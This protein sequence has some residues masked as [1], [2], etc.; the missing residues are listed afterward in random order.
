MARPVPVRAGDEPLAAAV[1]A[2][3]RA[4][5][6]ERGRQP[7]AK[8]EEVPPPRRLGLKVVDEHPGQKGV[9]VQPQPGGGGEVEPRV[10]QPRALSRLGRHCCSSHHGRRRGHLSVRRLLSGLHVACSSRHGRG[11]GDTVR[12]QLALARAG[13]S[14][15]LSELEC[16]AVRIRLA[17][18]LAL[19]QRKAPPLAVCSGPAAGSSA[20]TGRMQC[21]ERAKIGHTVSKR[22]TQWRGGGSRARHA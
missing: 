19:W 21:D 15:V 8:A 11:E 5:A 1:V 3:R 9:V 7:V 2:P 14:K 16:T 18:R 13:P 12:V 22:R 17:C 4:P 10:G 20:R 6:D